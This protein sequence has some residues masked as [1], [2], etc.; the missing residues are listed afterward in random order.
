MVYRVLAVGVDVLHAAAMVLWVGGIPLLFWRRWPRWTR[1]Y[2]YY[3]IGFIVVSQVSDFWL[4]ECFLTTLARYLYDLGGEAEST[5]TW[6][7]VRLAERVFRLRP[8][9]AAVR[10]ATKALIL[11]VCAG[12]LLDLYRARRATSSPPRYDRVGTPGMGGDRLS[13]GL[14]D[15]GGTPHRSPGQ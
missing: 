1:A 15:A 6:F 10:V 8:S 12:T 14:H 11:I 3:S 9:E 7:T 5:R 2:V 4:G 13:D